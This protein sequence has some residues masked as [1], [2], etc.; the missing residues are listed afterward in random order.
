MD[1]KTKI[2]TKVH[3]LRK[4]LYLYKPQIERKELHINQAYTDPRVEE[5]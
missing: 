5:A 4:R 2:N 3:T 1:F